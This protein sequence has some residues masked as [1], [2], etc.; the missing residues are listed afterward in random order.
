MCGI[1]GFIDRSNKLNIDDLKKSTDMLSHRGRDDSG[2]EFKHHESK[3]V[4]FGH[5]RLSILDLSKAGHQPYFFDNLMMTYN[6]EVYN[7]QT[8][9]EEL[10]TNGYTFQSTSDTEVIIKAFHKWGSSFVEKLNGMF[11]IA[12][13][14]FNSG[15]LYLFR[16][17]MGIKPLYYYL[18]SNTFAFASELSSIIVLK[19]FSKELDYKSIGTFLSL[20]YI[21]A[22]MSIYKDVYKLKQGHYAVLKPDMNVETVSYWNPEKIYQ[23]SI[24]M[25][26]ISEEEAVE[27]FQRLLDDSV[28]KRMIS[29]VPLGVFLS[30]GY[31]S[32]LVAATAQKVSDNPIN[33]Y[34]IGNYDKKLNEANEARIIS[35]YLGT[36][37]HE[38]YIGSDEVKA[39]V[40]DIS[41][42]YSEPFG[43]SSQLPTMLVSKI[44]KQ[45]VS[46]ALTG[47]GGDE[48]FGGYDQYRTIPS[49][50][51]LKK[52]SV[53]WK[54][55]YKAGV[56]DLL[57]G[58]KDNFIVLPHINSLKTSMYSQAYTVSSMIE[59]IFSNNKSYI[60][61][62]INF[63][64]TGVSN[65]EKVMMNGM[66]TGLADDMLHKVDRG[67]M[68]FE[69]ETRV[70]LLDHRIVEFSFRLPQFLKINGNTGK[71]ILKKLVYK[72]LPETVMNRPKKGFAV[73][74][75]EWLK[76]DFEEEYR[77]YL[78]KSFISNQGVFNYDVVQ[79]IFNNR[80]TK[81]HDKLN[82]NLF[83]FQNWW[84]HYHG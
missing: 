55:L 27:E 32:S 9:R 46:V 24:S 54:L 76:T 41:R 13:Y 11:A 28:R 68:R 67:A 42:Y 58:Y 53:L 43:D 70:P 19:N 65:I 6:G 15:K 79:K 69:L 77:S 20:G 57:S 2:Y 52:Y 62:E 21:P 10:E 78:S 45:G 4:G 80:K 64:N 48:V 60:E 3:S 50:L 25:R 37:H 66:I 51:K 12:I 31:D 49:K 39:L 83:M 14:D 56:I 47:D 71:Y 18:N 73:P 1:F 75:G 61:P 17:R 30:G 26:N 72:Y 33:T 44:A 36:N 82:W 34:S 38:F 63:Y 40:S 84:N 23:A 7:F 29:D 8:V 81:Y 22:P 74:V 16:D 59:S 5:R 35:E